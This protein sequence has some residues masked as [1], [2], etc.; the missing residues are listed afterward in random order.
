MF[1]LLV[2]HE[3]QDQEHGVFRVTKDRFLEHTAPLIRDALDSLSDDAIDAIRT[4]PCVLM[5]E[6]RGDGKVL[7]GEITK[8][9]Q[10]QGGI[11]I[12]F[13]PLRHGPTL[14]NADIWNLRNALGIQEFE[15][16]RNHWAVKDREILIELSRSDYEVPEELTSRFDFRP[17]PSPTRKQLL[18]A[19]NTMAELGH[20]DIDDFLLEAGVSSL[21][22]DRSA[23]SRKDRANAIVKFILENPGVVTAENR[24]LSVLFIEWADLDGTEND[25]DDD[26]TDVR[27]HGDGD[28]ALPVSSNLEKRSTHPN[29]VFVVH[30]QDGDTRDKIVAFLQGAGLH[31]VVLHEQP[32]MGRHLLTKFIEEAELVTFAVVLMTDDDIGGPKGGHQRSRARQNVILELGYFLAHLNQGRVCAM[33]TPGVETPSDFDGIVYI[34]IDETEQWKAELLR[35]LRAA[36]MPVT[37]KIGN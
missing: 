20:T 1:N 23:G 35:E 3:A 9:E 25:V 13:M 14:L 29:R 8:V 2:T 10:T 17:L 31:P 28:I 34:T 18:A 16:N 6:G 11:S 30:G 5:D 12:H 33:K 21:E 36:E 19:R 24:L 4:W 32:N 27:G 15:F 22:A 26:S 37:N 7:L